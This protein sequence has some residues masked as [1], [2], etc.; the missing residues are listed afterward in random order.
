MHFEPTIYEGTNEEQ[1]QKVNRYNNKFRVVNT[2]K[3]R[4]NMME[5]EEEDKVRAEDTMEQVRNLLSEQMLTIKTDIEKQQDAFEKRLSARNS[6]L[7]LA[8]VIKIYNEVAF[9]IFHVCEYKIH[10]RI[11]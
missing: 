6:A 5:Y 10:S 8:A 11:R 4:P 2:M 7:H 9:I 3:K 1:S